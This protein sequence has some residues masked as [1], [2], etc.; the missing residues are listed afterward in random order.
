SGCRRRVGDGRVHGLRRVSETHRWSGRAGNWCASH[1]LR[2]PGDATVPP[3]D[4]AAGKGVGAFHATYE[5]RDRRGF[6]RGD[7]IL[8]SSRARL[9]NEENTAATHID[10][11]RGRLRGA[12]GFPW[13]SGGRGRAERRRPGTDRGRV[14]PSWTL[15]EGSLSPMSSLRLSVVL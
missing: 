13:K 14:S 15:Q 12:F 1:T 10:V 2:R 3:V 11:V 8:S 6:R 7:E 5:R 9:P 4:P